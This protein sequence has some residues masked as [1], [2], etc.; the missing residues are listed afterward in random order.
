MPQVYSNSPRSSDGKRHYSDKRPGHAQFFVDRKGA[1]REGRCQNCGAGL[2]TVT[3]GYP[4][5]SLPFFRIMERRAVQGGSAVCP[6]TGQGDYFDQL[7]GVN[8]HN[9]YYRTAQSW[10]ETPLVADAI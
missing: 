8:R 10:D 2:Y 7:Q 3:V 5:A 1:R 4:L 6:V 9:L